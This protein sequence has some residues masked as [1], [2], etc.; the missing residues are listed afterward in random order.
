MGRSVGSLGHEGQR[1]PQRGPRRNRSPK[2]ESAREEGDQIWFVFNVVA[3][4]FLVAMAATYVGLARRAF[5]E[6][7]SHLQSRVHSTTARSLATSPVLQHRVGEI[8]ARLQAARA[9]CL[10]AA[11]DADVGD[12]LALPNLCAAKAEVASAAVDLVGECM[13]L[14]GGIGYAR[15]GVLSRLLRDA[16]AAHVMSPTTDLLHTWAGRSLLGQPLLVE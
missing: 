6:A 13:T 4:V 8:W 5:D 10:A 14:C 3:P 2:G 16:R 1:L 7:R 15:G 9:L 11:H 12:E